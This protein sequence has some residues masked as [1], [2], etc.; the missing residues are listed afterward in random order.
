MMRWLRHFV[1]VSASKKKRLWMVMS[2]IILSSSETFSQR[3]WLFIA[4]FLH[5]ENCFVQRVIVFLFLL[6]RTLF[7]WETRRVF[8]GKQRTLTLLVLLFHA[9]RVRV[10]YMLF[11][12]CIYYFGCFMFFV[13]VCFLC[14]VLSLNYILLIFTR[15]M[16]PLITLL[17]LHTDP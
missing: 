9:P 15:I 12:F 6:S 1:F 5:H 4:S 17:Q 14:L 13:W 7:L 10:A 3:N 2:V 8:L 16:F 11:S